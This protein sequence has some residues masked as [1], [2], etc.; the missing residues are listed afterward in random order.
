MSARRADGADIGRR[1][2][3]TRLTPTWAAGRRHRWTSW[4]RARTHV[5]SVPGERARARRPGGSIACVLVG[6][7]HPAAV[8]RPCRH[9]TGHVSHGRAFR[10][11]RRRW[12]LAHVEA[13]VFTP[14]A[15]SH[16]HHDRRTHRTNREK[17]VRRGAGTHGHVRGASRNRATTVLPTDL[18]GARSRPPPGATGLRPGPPRSCRQRVRSGIGDTPCSAG[19]P[20]LGSGPRRHATGGRGGG[21]ANGPPGAT[22]RSDGYS[23]NGSRN[24][25]AHRPA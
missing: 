12:R 21:G 13:G 23:V 2:G 14:D 18:A 6:C 17:P 19:S 24:V 16:R 5:V 9:T 11:T 25:S 4:E 1:A 7:R 20:A 15:R 10:P 22:A 3:R 8:G